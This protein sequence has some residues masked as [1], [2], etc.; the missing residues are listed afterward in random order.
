M[1]GYQETSLGLA[2]AQSTLKN[3]DWAEFGTGRGY[4]TARIYRF[5]PEKIKLHLF[6]WFEG[7][8]E[9]W[10]RIG[11]SLVKKGHFKCEPPEWIFDR[12]NIQVHLGLFE[13]T[14]PIFAEVQ[15]RPLCFIN[16]DCDL[17]SSTKTIFDNIDHLI[18]A[19]TIIHFDEYYNF[20]SWE[21]HEFK[22]FMEYTVNYDRDF[23]Y[24]GRTNHNQVWIKIIK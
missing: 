1:F 4:S 5:I 19:G 2:I 7:L 8:P 12:P 14:I 24:L 20:G 3:C 17:Y 22:A 13:E 10:T 9:D 21:Q 18:R 15:K 11:G 23:K 6:D 16:I